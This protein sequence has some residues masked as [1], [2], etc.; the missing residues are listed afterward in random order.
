MSSNFPVKLF[1][2]LILPALIVAGFFVI[3]INYPLSTEHGE[4]IRQPKAGPPRA[5]N[6]EQD[7]NKVVIENPSENKNINTDLQTENEDVNSEAENIIGQNEDTENDTEN[8]EIKSDNAASKI[9]EVEKESNE[10]SE[11]K[12]KI[13]QNLVSWGYAVSSE[14]NIDTIIIHSS[15]DALGNDPYDLDGLLKEYK[16]YGV[17]P[18]YVIDRKGKIYRLVTDKNIAYHAG[19][20]Q[21]P[22]GRNGVNN[23]SIGIELINTEDDEYTENQYK[24][25]SELIDYLKNEHTIKY[26]LGHSQIAPGRKTDPWNFDYTRIE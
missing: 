6:Y 16:L 18:H 3:F 9:K 22:D 26:I 25:L 24:A 21:M 4:L 1:L 15:Y 5:E 23:F 11:P 17:A 14:R 10:K 20:S 7:N 12:I 19:A 8:V 2:F 13:I